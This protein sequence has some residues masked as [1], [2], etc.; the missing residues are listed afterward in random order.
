M[1]LMVRIYVE[2]GYNLIMDGSKKDHIDIVQ[3]Y[4]ITKNSNGQSMN[5][6]A[7]KIK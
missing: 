7:A 2:V 6:T 5:F 3:K 4:N 1:S